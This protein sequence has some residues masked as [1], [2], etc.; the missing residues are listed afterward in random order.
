MLHKK[1]VSEGWVK[2]WRDFVYYSIREMLKFKILTW[3]IT[4]DVSTHCTGTFCHTLT[5][6]MT[7]V[8][9]NNISDCVRTD[10]SPYVRLFGA[11][12]SKHTT[13]SLKEYEAKPPTMLNQTPGGKKWINNK[14]QINKNISFVEHSHMLF[15]DFLMLYNFHT[16]LSKWW[17]NQSW[18]IFIVDIPL[19]CTYYEL[20]I[21]HH[22]HVHGDW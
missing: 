12:T 10:A 17:D 2:D 3:R 16:I 6:W 22:Q 5:R 21:N 11:A 4:L 8:K 18:T 14:A 13:A 1:S 20:V 19:C 9:R 7:V 15:S